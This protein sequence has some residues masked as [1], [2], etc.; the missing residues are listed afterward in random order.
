MGEARSL[1]RS[2]TDEVL[3]VALRV[4]L[5]EI[6]RRFWP[7]TWAYRGRFWISLLLVS[8]APLHRDRAVDF[9]SY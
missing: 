1:A 5:R 6:F 9:L 4:G 3:P 8:V 7:D 2:D